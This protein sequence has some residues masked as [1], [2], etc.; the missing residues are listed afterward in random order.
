MGAR[1]EF[2]D[3][4][5]WLACAE[6]SEGH[7][8]SSVMWCG[9]NG[10]RLI[11]QRQCDEDHFKF[12]SFKSI[13]LFVSIMRHHNRQVHPCKMLIDEGFLSAYFFQAD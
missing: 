1:G 8:T 13:C 9:K 12:C 5:K 3:S 4:I 2:G 7:S 10:A 11:N 6:S